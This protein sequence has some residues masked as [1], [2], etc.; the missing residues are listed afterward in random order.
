MADS[1]ASRKYFD[2]VY[3]PAGLIILGCAITKSEWVP[4]AV[5]LS[6][7]LAAYKFNSMQV[8]K[9][10][11]PD[12][13]QEFELKEK[14]IISHNVAI[15]RF[16][17]PS[18]K[19]VLGLPIGQHISIGANCPQPDG[20]TKEIVRSYTPISGDHQ[21]GYFD[22]LIKSYPTGNI[23]KHMASMKVG[24][25]LKVKGPKGAFV[26]T[27]NMVRHFGM[28]A[29]GTGITPMLQIIRAVIRGRPTGDRTEIDL[30]FAN[31]TVQD[32]LLKE[33]LDALAKEDNGFRVHY[34]LDKPPADWTGGVG[35]VT[36]DMITKLLPK[37]ADDVKLLLCG[38][39]PMVSGL[40]KTSESLGFKKARPV[41]KL[42]DQV[43]AF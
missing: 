18:E 7:A 15:Y 25:T 34:V 14:T 12:A 41:S 35:Y 22:L 37:P 4:Y 3:I 9:V 20:T 29:G 40:K 8:K 21:P 43:F 6:L 10:L 26:Y 24:Q 16:K 38:P 11:K 5:L 33:D 23:S 30:I 32:I 27:P 31:V 28:I 1:L 42:E 19:S 2:N 13:F 17:L 36:A 39:P